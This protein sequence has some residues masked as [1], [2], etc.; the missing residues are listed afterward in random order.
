MNDLVIAFG[1]NDLHTWAHNSTIRGVKKV[2]VN[3]LYSRENASEHL[4]V[5]QLNKPIENERVACLST[6]ENELTTK[7]GKTA[8]VIGWGKENSHEEVNS[9]L[10]IATVK[11]VDTEE[12]KDANSTDELLQSENIFCAGMF[13]FQ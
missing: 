12:C 2:F 3:S 8:L 4:A 6:D 11:I 1:Q 9:L 5:V 7:I 10:N 13:W